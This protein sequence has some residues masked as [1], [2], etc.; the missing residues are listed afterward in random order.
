MVVLEVVFGVDSG[1]FGA[2][3]GVSS[4]FGVSVVILEVVFEGNL[5]VFCVVV[6]V[7]GMFGVVS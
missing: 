3:L 6:G 4:V 1:V 7:S 2:M 5:G